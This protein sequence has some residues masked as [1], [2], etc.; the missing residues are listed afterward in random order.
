MQFVL[1]SLLSTRASNK[2]FQ[3]L[4]FFFVTRLDS[5]RVVK[6]ITHMVGEHELVVDP[7]LAS[8]APCLEVTDEKYHRY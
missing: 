8:L 1:Q 7:V 6:D 3:D 2:F 4:E 5:L